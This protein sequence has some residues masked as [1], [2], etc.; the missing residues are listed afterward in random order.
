VPA[1]IQVG[2]AAHVG[3]PAQ[4]LRVLRSGENEFAPGKHLRRTAEELLDLGL[5]VGG[6]GAHVTEVAFKALA[7]G[8]GAILV[9]IKRTI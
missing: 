8:K 2:D 9:G 4:S 6:V 3:R 5:A 1:R 7:D